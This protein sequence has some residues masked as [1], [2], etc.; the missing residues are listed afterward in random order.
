MKNTLKT[1]IA[2]ILMLG[3]A[4][5]FASDTQHANHQAAGADHAAMAPD[6]AKLDANSDGQL[7]KS[8]LPKD[9]PMAAH[10]NMMDKDKDGKVS[11]A[12]FDA[13]N[14]NHSGH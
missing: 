6:F 8:E 12:E 2:L 13:M 7:E 9:H 1:T 3:A 4:Q 5:S 11:K 10:F 14:A